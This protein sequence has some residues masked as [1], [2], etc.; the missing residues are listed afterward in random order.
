MEYHFSLPITDKDIKKL[1]VGDVIYISGNIFTA[2]D[3]AHKMMLESDTKNLPFNPS[4]MGL[5][6]CG[7]L[8]RETKKGWDVVSA[9]PTTSNRMELFEYEFIKKFGTQV[10]IGKGGMG[11]KTKQ[12]LQEYNAVY[13]AYPGGAGALAAD[14]IKEVIGVYW[15]EELGMP[16]A[17]WVF[18]VKDFGPLV[19]AMDSYG[20]SLYKLK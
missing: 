20:K 11:E 13:T 14:K 19:V 16:E 12:A 8:M 1:T 2:R 7:P 4:N 17:I 6:H 5:F 15:L 10:I 18:K 9:G 3:E